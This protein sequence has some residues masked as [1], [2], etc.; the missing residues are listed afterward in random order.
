[1][2]KNRILAP[3]LV[4]G[5]SPASPSLFQEE[6]READN[7]VT[8]KIPGPSPVSFFL[9]LPSVSRRHFNLLAEWGASAGAT[10]PSHA[11]QPDTRP[12][13]A[14]GQIFPRKIQTWMG[15]RPRWQARGQRG[16]R[17]WH[18]ECGGISFSVA[19]CRG[20]LWASAA[21]AW[22][23]PGPCP[24]S[25]LGIQERPSSQGPRLPS[26]SMCCTGVSGS[27][28]LGSQGPGSS[29]NIDQKAR[30]MEAVPCH[31][32]QVWPGLCWGGLQGKTHGNDV[33]DPH[34]RS[35]HPEWSGENL[36]R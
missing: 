13:L 2:G 28:F 1:M 14:G 5:G 7:Y 25:F 19:K 33:A 3:R 35:M 8:L 16:S 29:L 9:P 30:P 24:S 4:N 36:G 22:G 6:A 11:W 10:Y 18:A 31:L 27:L 12:K 26:C 15:R 23:C 21:G 34:E 32:S 20:R 17:R